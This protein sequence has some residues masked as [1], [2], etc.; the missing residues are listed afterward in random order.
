MQIIQLSFTLLPTITVIFMLDQAQPVRKGEE[1]DAERLM[2]YL[3]DQLLPSTHLEI[4]QFPSGFSNLTYLIRFGI[5]E[6]VLRRPPYGANIKSGHD[7]EREFK[8][9]SA[10]YGSFSKVPQPIL[11]C[12]DESVLGAPFYLMERVNGVILRNQDTGYNVSLSPAVMR[13]L[14]TKLVETLVEIHAVDLKATGLAAMG[15]PE[16]YVQRQVEGWTRRYQAAQTDEIIEMDIV[17]EW[18]G[19]H[20]PPERYV[21][22]IHNDFKYDNVVLNL[23]LS[24]IIAVLDWEMSTVGDPLMD[25]GTCL[26]YWIEPTDPAPMRMFGLTALPGNLSRQEVAQYYAEK[27]GRQIGDLLFYYVYGMFKT[28]VIIQQI[29]YRYRKGFTQDARFAPLIHVLKAFAATA[30]QALEKGRIDQLDK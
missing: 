23:E 4:R 29:Y 30:V 18:L 22:F 25:L 13:N 12:E 15:K 9:L 10:L 21:S 11:F 24:E 2:A 26:S 7:M 17:A 3:S 27:S 19:N 20:L 8:V 14:S 1:P 5:Q 6:Y 16:G 28:G